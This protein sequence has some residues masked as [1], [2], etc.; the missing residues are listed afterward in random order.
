MAGPGRVM[1]NAENYGERFAIEPKNPRYER[2]LIP[3]NAEPLSDLLFTLKPGRFLQRL[4]PG[5]AECFNYL[6]SNDIRVEVRLQNIEG[7]K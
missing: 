5:S 7:V 6:L 1:L 4:W 2:Y 3:S